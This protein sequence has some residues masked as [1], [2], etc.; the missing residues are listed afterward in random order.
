MDSWAWI[1]ARNS[2]AFLL[3]FL[4]NHFFNFFST[5]QRFVGGVSPPL[6]LNKGPSRIV[7]LVG[8]RRH[9]ET[10]FF[11]DTSLIQH[12][13]KDLPQ[14]SH[15][16]PSSREQYVLTTFQFN[17]KIKAVSLRLVMLEIPFRLVFSKIVKKVHTL[18]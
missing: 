8:R 2:L 10:K 13:S 17:S 1:S 12:W 11:F 7:R 6:L 14:H 16:G 4:L 3:L 5:H 9:S 15:S 18:C